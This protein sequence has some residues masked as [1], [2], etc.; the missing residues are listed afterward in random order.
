M[1]LEAIIPA[2]KPDETIYKLIRKLRQQTVRP[3]RIKVIL[4]VSDGIDDSFFDPVADTDLMIELIDKKDFKHGGTR[5]RAAMSS[6]ARYVLFLTQDGIPYDDHMTA[7]LIEAVSAKNAA[8][9][10]ARQIPYPDSGAI[11]KYSRH[12]NYPSKS[13]SKNYADIEKYGIRAVFC[14]DTCAVYDM[15][16]FKELGGFYYNADFNEDEIYAYKALC[17]GYTVEYNADAKIFHSHDYTV[18]EQF[19]RYKAIATSQREHP[20]IFEKM[21]CISEGKKYVIKGFFF[22]LRH[23]RP[24]TAIKFIYVSFVKY[25]AFVY[26]KYIT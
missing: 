20:E 2:Y 7:H 19:S 22:F 16:I 23:F 25:L 5:Q 4:T 18:K 3:E 21:G 1:L 12:Y 24:Y 10:Y 13:S 14:S 8:L 17:N 6:D 26:G 11:E 15:E 9:A